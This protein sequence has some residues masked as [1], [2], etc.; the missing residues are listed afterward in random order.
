LKVA[1]FRKLDRRQT[2]REYLANQEE[3]HNEAFLAVC[4]CCGVLWVAHTTDEGGLPYAL[5]CPEAGKEHN[6]CEYAH[7]EIQPDELD[8]PFSWFVHHGVPSEGDSWYNLAVWPFDSDWGEPIG[9]S[10]VH[11]SEFVEIA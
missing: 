8:K 5:E 7:L 2:V 3:T 11:G 10:P 6:G 9:N 1:E 4:A